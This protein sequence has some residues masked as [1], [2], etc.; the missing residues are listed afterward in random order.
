[1]KQL[2]KI[3]GGVSIL[4]WMKIAGVVM[5]MGI[6]AF[7]NHQ[8]REKNEEIRAMNISLD[9]AVAVADSTKLLAARLEDSLYVYQ[10]QVVQLT[11]IKSELEKKYKQEVKARANL[12]LKL[13][14]VKVDTVTAVQSVN[15]D[16]LRVADFHVYEAPITIDAHVELEREQGHAEFTVAVDPIPLRVELSCGPAVN[17]F[18]SANIYVATPFQGV[19]ANVKD[20]VQDAETCN[21]IPYET[22]LNTWQKINALPLPLKLAIPILTFL[23]ITR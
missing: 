18:R 20:V 7:Q 14:E 8:I 12:E 22:K 11:D 4:T 6:M 3:L 15:N 9:S 16:S 21:P 2:G 1:M 13:A 5:T 17:G 19:V 10:R 23:A